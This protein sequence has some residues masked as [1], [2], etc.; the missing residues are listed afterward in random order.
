VFQ[1]RLPLDPAV[2]ITIHH[3]AFLHRMMLRGNNSSCPASLPAV[4]Y[5]RIDA[6]CRDRPESEVTMATIPA[7]S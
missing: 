7:H 4:Y 6:A 3:I 1:S 5:D 2:L